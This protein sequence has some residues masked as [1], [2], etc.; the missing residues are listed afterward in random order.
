MNA[1]KIKYISTALYSYSAVDFNADLLRKITIDDLL[2]IIHLNEDNKAVFRAAWA[3]EHLLLQDPQLLAKYQVNIKQ[4][5]LQTKNWSALRCI[6]KLL[7]SILQKKSATNTT[8]IQGL[9]LDKTFDLL[10]HQDTP[11]AVRCN[12]YDLAFLLAQKEKWILSELKT[13]IYFDLEKSPTPA[14]KSRGKRM[15]QKLERIA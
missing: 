10:T 8:E 13:Q 2:F 7:I 4:V 14:L 6:S 15:L 11:I 12:I 5:Y 3:L 9:L 1:H